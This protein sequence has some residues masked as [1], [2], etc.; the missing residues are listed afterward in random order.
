M[1]IGLR[2]TDGNVWNDLMTIEEIKSHLAFL[3]YC[4][5]PQ[6]CIPT[7]K[8]WDALFSFMKEQA[9]LGVG[10][11][12]VERMK[13]EGAEVPR[14]VVLKW[15]AV[16]E[17]IR[18][19]NVEMNRRCVELVK[20]LREDGFECCVLKGQGNAVMYPDPFMRA[21]GDIDVWVSPLQLPQRGERGIRDVNRKGE[22]RRAI[23]EYARK[24][25]PKAEVR[26]YHVEYEW[27]GVPVELHFMPGVMNNPFYNRRLQRWYRE[28]M[29]EQCRHEVE[30][31]DGVG[32][33][34]VPTWEFNVVY[35]LAHLMHHFF[36]E[37]IGLRQ[38]MDY[39]YL[40]RKTKNG[41]GFSVEELER[42][43]QYLGLYKF[44]K[45]VMWVL[46]EVFRLEEEHYIVPPDE[47]RGRLL[48]EEII[49]G[50]NFGHYSGLTDHSIGTKHFLKIRR[51][52]R[53]FRAY[54]AEALCEPWFRTWHFFWRMRHK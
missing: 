32:K 25:M 53:F 42:I 17:Q 12:G 10:F 5:D 15:F 44:A 38:M 46:H 21:S 11:R 43:L 33:I 45:A 24:E 29:A 23:V 20:R 28:R 37:G 6:Q 9:L 49:K 19:R 41:L 3:C 31:P 7:I 47:W 36:D 18:Q 2:I 50:G 51:N 39:Y 34:P 14:E 4:I 48:L 54:P 1:R 27:G 13:S 40:V 22:E 26:C 8:D 30:L 35:Q 52:M 16:S